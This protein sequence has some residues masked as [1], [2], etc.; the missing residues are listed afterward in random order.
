MPAHAT[1]RNQSSQ[2]DDFCVMVVLIGFAAR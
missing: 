2:V 1:P